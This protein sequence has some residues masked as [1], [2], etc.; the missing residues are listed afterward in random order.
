MAYLNVAEIESALLNLATAY[1]KT[2]E[3]LPC[4]NLTHEQR[5]THV[6]RIGT[7]GPGAAD[8]VLL[9]GGVHGREWVP[10]DALV[11]L[12]AD[13]LEAHARGT[14]LGYGGATFSAGDVRRI[15]E[16]LN[17]FVCPCLN[18]DG[19][20]HS[21]TNVA[22]WRKNRRPRPTSGSCDGVDLNRNFDFLWDHVHKFAA[23]SR[24]Q[25]SADP[26]S[27]VYR[28]PSPASEPEVRNVL[29]L[30]DSHP[31]IRW[32]IDVHS[33][34]PAVLYSWGS[35]QDQTTHPDQT[36][37]NSAFDTVRG[38]PGDTA[39]REYIAAPDLAV[40]TSVATRV[41]DAVKAVR[42]DDYGVEQAFGLYPTSGAS[43]DYAFSRHAADPSTPMVYG[44]TI[45]CG[46]SF[47][48]A[49]SEAE[50][51]IREVSAGLMG[52][53]LA[54]AP[55]EGKEILQATGGPIAALA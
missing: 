37:L 55:P 8:G 38:R 20:H 31:R 18:P 27:D 53:C 12:A 48:P 36:F 54:A 14:G 40:V 28:G 41:N 45:E 5:R 44:F 24:V 52:F 50:E 26:C 3:L 39:Y 21:Q 35:D 30:L 13:L 11:S 46:H 47:Q 2:A 49:W 25:T 32:H 17:L 16:T 43:D 51:V 42:G 4:P 1:P 33:A 15:V 34:V 29:W 7:Q 22:L 23:D 10:P 6:L 9:L 19:R